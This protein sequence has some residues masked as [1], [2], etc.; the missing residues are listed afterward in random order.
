MARAPR[1]TRTPGSAAVTKDAAQLVREDEPV[2]RSFPEPLADRVYKALWDRIL[3][4]HVRPGQKLS[5]VRISQELGVSRTPVREALQRLVQEGVVRVEANRGFYVMSFSPKDVE[6]IYDL[7][8]AL[9]PMALELAI[10]RLHPGVLVESLS[11]LDLLDAR[12]RV[13]G[14]EEERMA[15][16]ADF[17]N[18]D[19]AFHR[20]IAERADNSRMQ[21]ALEG[22]WAQIAVFQTAGIRR[23]WTEVSIQ[24]HRRII[25]ALQIGDTAAGIQALR[26]HIFE[27][28]RMIVAEIVHDLESR[29]RRR[30]GRRTTL[31]PERSSIDEGI[32]E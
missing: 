9:E 2:R 17:L 7:R 25:A 29:E 19:R 31:A 6:E 10:P 4:R 13:A 14:T 32:E 22:L 18:I 1:E 5:D 8:V 23:G 16:A 30:R 11:E 15:I 28:K 12:S 20:M 27:V 3:E 21:S 24:H 26:D